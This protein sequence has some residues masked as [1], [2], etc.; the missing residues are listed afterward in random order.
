MRTIVAIDDALYQQALESAE[1][2]VDKP[3]ATVDPGQAACRYGGEIRGRLD[4]AGP[5]I[6]LAT[7]TSTHGIAHCISR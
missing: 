4:W 3:Y 1:P 2:G 7:R 6:W 5:S